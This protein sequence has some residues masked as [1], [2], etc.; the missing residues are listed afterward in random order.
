MKEIQ[1]VWQ[2]DLEDGSDFDDE[3]FRRR[4]RE[5]E[6]SV[7]A[8]RARTANANGFNVGELRFGNLSL[9]K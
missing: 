5:T 6:E 4:E 7:A 2:V 3:A 9:R 1:G 8:K